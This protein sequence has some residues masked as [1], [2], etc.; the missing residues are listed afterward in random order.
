MVS[1]H[2][3]CNHTRKQQKGCHKCVYC[4]KLGHTIDRGYALHDRT[5]Q[6]ATIVQIAPLQT[7]IAGPTSSGTPSSNISGQPT[8]FNKFLKWYDD[9]QISSSP[10]SI[11]HTS[12][13]FVGLAHSTSFGPWILDSGATNHITGNKYFFLPCLL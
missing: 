10:A 12:I 3:D 6:F 4:H 8:I 11:A 13:S 5:P 2:D 9:H 7:P 1:L